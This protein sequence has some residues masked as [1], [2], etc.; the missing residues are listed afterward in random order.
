MTPRHAATPEQFGEAITR[1]PGPDTNAL[2]LTVAGAAALLGMSTSTF[3]RVRATGSLPR[4]RRVPGRTDPMYRRK[5]L[6][7]WVLRLREARPA[8][9]SE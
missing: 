9:P 2:L 7:Q 5:D 4:P 3:E 8:P 1:T 6:E